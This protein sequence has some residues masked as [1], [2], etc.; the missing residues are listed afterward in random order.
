[1]NDSQRL[2][3]AARFIG[4][5]A[6]LNHRPLVSNDLK[7][8]AQV[9]VIP[10][11][12]E[13]KNLAHTLES[14]GRNP[15][16]ERERTLVICVVNNRSEP[17]ARRDQIEDNQR[18]LGLLDHLVHGR[19][20]PGHAHV[21]PGRLR[22]AYVDA[23]SLGLE[24]GQKMGVGEGRRIGLDH[25]LRVLF[26]NGLARAPLMCLDADTLVSENYLSEVRKHLSAPDAWAAAVAYEHPLPQEPAQRAAILRYE[27]FLRY[28][29]LALRWAASPYAFPTIGSTIVTRSDAYVASGG[30]NRRQA[31]E[32]FYFLQQL[33][34]TGGISRINTTKVFPSSRSSDRVPFGTGAS[35]GRYIGCE[36]EGYAVYNTESFRVLGEWLAV[37]RDGLELSADDLLQRAEAIHQELRE[38]LSERDFETVW[39]RLQRNASK[40]ENLEAQFHR[41]F[42]G[43][44]TLK[45]VHHLRD[46]VFPQ[47][48]IFSAVREILEYLELGC[49]SILWE[50]LHQ[51]LDSQLQLL[52]FV[53][54]VT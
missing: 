48:P 39:P 24:I 9:V 49:N 26:D 22:L 10:V 30:M 35:V 23:S 51:D 21:T 45:L 53:R 16:D 15:A 19:S 4:K 33:A 52:Q 2:E 34:K 6:D 31:G 28:H 47:Q 32:D 27:L 12:A 13:E 1:M 11:L 14:L 42:D 18:T 54:S 7:G 20:V 41:W 43:F 38:F 25:G 50:D 5:R 8:I 17:H 44:K 36:A 46:T 37:V 29:E 3:R 40:S